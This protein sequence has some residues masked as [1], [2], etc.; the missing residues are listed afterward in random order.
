MKSLL[1]AALALATTTAC[2]PYSYETGGSITP[3]KVVI[4]VNI[5]PDLG[6]KWNNQYPAKF[7]IKYKDGTA[8][9]KHKFQDGKIKMELMLHKDA[10]ETITI[11]ASFSLCTPKVCRAFRNKEFT[12]SFG[13]P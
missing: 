6:W 7:R 1:I 2:L 3:E 9:A 8:T 5:Q 10:P 11:I 4:Y 13:A 12:I